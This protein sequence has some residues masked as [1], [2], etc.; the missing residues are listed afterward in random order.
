VRTM[1]RCATGTCNS[2]GAACNAK[3]QRLYRSNGCET[4]CAKYQK[5]TTA[6]AEG[7]GF[8]ACK[9]RCDAAVAPSYGAC[10]QRCGALSGSDY[11]KSRCRAACSEAEPCNPTSCGGV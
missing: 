6:C 4:K 5:C 2:A 1:D 10:S 7:A 11:D 3:Q 8:D 9:A